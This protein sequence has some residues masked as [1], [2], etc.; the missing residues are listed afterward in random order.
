MYQQPLNIVFSDYHYW[1]LYADGNQNI[2]FYNADYSESKALIWNSELNKY[3]E[4]DF[5]NPKVE[6]PKDFCN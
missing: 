1:T 2:Y 3:N 6:L 5:C 4:L